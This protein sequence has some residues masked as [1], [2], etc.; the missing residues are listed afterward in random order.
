MHCGFVATS[1]SEWTKHHSLTLAATKLWI[2]STIALGLAPGPSGRAF[3]AGTSTDKPNVIFIVADD[4]GYGDLKC[5]G[6]PYIDTPV[7][8]QPT[9]QLVVLAGNHSTSLG[10]AA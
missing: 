8:D 5:Y 2:G 3:A 7:L 4:L 1:V 6:N 9:G 10:N